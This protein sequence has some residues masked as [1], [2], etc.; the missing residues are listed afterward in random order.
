MPGL[1]GHLKKN[2]TIESLERLAQAKGDTQ[3]AREM[4]EAKRKL[5]AGFQ[6]RRTA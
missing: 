3:A 4:Q 5:F 2:V 1:T 6:Q